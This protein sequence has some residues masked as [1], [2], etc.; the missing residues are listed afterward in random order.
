MGV[1]EDKD[2]LMR[3]TARAIEEKLLTKE[4]GVIRF[5]GDAYYGGRPWPVTTAWLALR[6][7][8]AG[9]PASA[10]ARFDTLT[11][12]AR[13]SDALMQGEQFDEDTGKWLSAFPLAWSEA[14]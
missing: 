6:H 1:F 14:V 8:A 11:R 5:E 3:A 7:H 10:R 12:Y 2:P 9:D 13:Q 4:G